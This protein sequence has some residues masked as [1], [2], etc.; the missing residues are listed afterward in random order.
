MAIGLVAETKR[1][2]VA[3]MLLRLLAAQEPPAIQSAAA[4]GVSRLA[5]RGLAQQA[6]ADWGQY[7]PGARRDLL[8]AL[9]RA[10]N[11]V[12]VL[13][14]VLE[15]KTLT[16]PDLDPAT[17]EALRR[18]PDVAARRRAETL[19]ASGAVVSRREAL[20]QREAALQLPGDATLGAGVFAKNCQACHRLQ[21]QGHR[22]GAD[23]SGISGKPKETLLADILDPN[24]EVPPDFVNYV[25][26]AHDG[27]ILTG[28]VVAETAASVKLRR[29]EGIEESVLRREIQELRS[30]GKSLM[31]EGLEQVLSTSDLA[32]LLEFLKRP[33]PLPAGPSS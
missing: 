9:L 26:I 27:R 22:V 5:D 13:L 16:L 2:T 19:L 30:T 8:A 17:R 33:I 21:G 18:L 20:R 31:P 23:L 1:D 29:A 14:D 24:R 25:L 7:T 28:M 10:P 3:P 6:L 15:Q 4:R 11:L 12:P 32:N